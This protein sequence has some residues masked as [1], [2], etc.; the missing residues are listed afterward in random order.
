MLVYGVSSHCVCT[1]CKCD[2][3]SPGE[4][5]SFRLMYLQ[6]FLDDSIGSPFSPAE[7]C[8]FNA[9]LRLKHCSV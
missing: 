8:N 7:Q 9:A 4:E 5:H 3:Q 6:A 1:F 2:C